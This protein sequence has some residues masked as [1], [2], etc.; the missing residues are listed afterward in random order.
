MVFI[1]W[2]TQNLPEF[3][4]IYKGQKSVTKGFLEI[5]E[6]RF[7]RK[8]ET[9]RVPVFKH[10]ACIQAYLTAEFD[11]SVVARRPA[12]TREVWDSFFCW[13][14]S[15]W[16]QFSLISQVATAN[17]KERPTVRTARVKCS[18]LHYRL[19]R[20]PS[21]PTWKSIIILGRWDCG[22]SYSNLKQEIVNM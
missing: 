14:Q 22:C 6:A 2:I 10:Y 11:V 3:N 15:T 4:R 12:S 7:A 8:D 19:R 17:S 1:L 13:A 18:A 5:N 9:F 20:P 21:G 16:R